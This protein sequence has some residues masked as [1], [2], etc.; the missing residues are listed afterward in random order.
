MANRRFGGKLHSPMEQW[1]CCRGCH[2]SGNLDLKG[3]P[4]L[5]GDS[6]GETRTVCGVVGIGLCVYVCIPALRFGNLDE[7]GD[8]ACPS[9]RMFESKKDEGKEKDRDRKA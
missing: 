6:G 5:P 9:R 3:A 4:D 2:T 1:K 7:N 8:A